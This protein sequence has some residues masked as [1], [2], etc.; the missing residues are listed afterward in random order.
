MNSRKLA[1]VFAAGVVA[2]AGLPI[3]A[4]PA[5]AAPPTPRSAGT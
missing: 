2:V 4:G 5:A 3:M 1:V